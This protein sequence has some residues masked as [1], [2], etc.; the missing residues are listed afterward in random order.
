VLDSYGTLLLAPDLIRES[1][2][3][4]ALEVLNEAL[5][6]HQSSGDRVGEAETL[7]HLGTALRAAGR[8]DDA[9]EHHEAALAIA[10]DVGDRDRLATAL[11]GCGLT[12]ITRGHL[13]LAVPLVRSA[14]ARAQDLGNR[15]LEQRILETLSALNEATPSGTTEP[16]GDPGVR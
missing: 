2:E 13:D 14:L 4:S 12:H 3:P 5:A 1:D 8:L 15:A 10:S 16:D 9:L 6:M 11:L 7:D